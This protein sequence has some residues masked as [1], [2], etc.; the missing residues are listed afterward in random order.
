MTDIDP[1]VTESERA[2]INSM[3][4]SEILPGSGRTLHTSI[5]SEP[6][7]ETSYL[8]R[9]ELDRKAAGLPITDGIDLSRYEAPE[10]PSNDSDVAAWKETL[11]TAYTSSTYLSGR[12][13][14]LSLLEDLGK[15]AWLIA[16]SQ[17]EDILRQLEIELEE[18]KSATENVNKSRKAAQEG[19]RAEMTGLEETWK[20]GISRILE[21]EVGVEEVRQQILERRRVQAG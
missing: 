16:N 15:N 4:A 7:F 20:R 14:S 12:I 21:A 17:L 18:L 6:T 11:R 19:S 9:Q 5:A 3:I 2:R 10:G 13:S 8:M 1:N